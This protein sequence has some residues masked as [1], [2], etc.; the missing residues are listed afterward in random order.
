MKL[1]TMRDTSIMHEMPQH[2]MEKLVGH[3][4]KS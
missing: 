2:Y 3:M 1:N 4:K